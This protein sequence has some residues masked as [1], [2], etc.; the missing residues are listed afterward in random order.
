MSMRKPW[1]L[2]AAL[3][4]PLASA[5]AEVR[6][7]TVVERLMTIHAVNQAGG[8]EPGKD[9]ACHMTFPQFIGLPVRTDYA[10]D[11][12]TLVMRA[13]SYFEAH[14]YPLSALGLANVYAFA[15]YFKPSPAY[16]PMLLS[17]QFRISTQFDHAASR[18]LLNLDPQTNCVLS[19]APFEP[20]DAA[21]ALP[22]PEKP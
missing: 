6:Q 1:L 5:H 9:A 18:L 11:P 16:L 12:Q 4:L 7:S 15:A 8:A 14:R 10:I 19:S 21:P 13:E 2:A 22:A 17:V 3:W 20:L